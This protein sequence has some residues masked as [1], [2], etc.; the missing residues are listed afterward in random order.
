MAVMSQTFYNVV[1][2]HAQLLAGP[3]AFPTDDDTGRWF[4]SASTGSQINFH[5]EGGTA[6]S[7]Q[8]LQ[9]LSPGTCKCCLVEGKSLCRCDSNEDLDIGSL[10][11]IVRAGPERHRLITG[12]CRGHTHRRGDVKMGQRDWRM[13]PQANECRQPPTA[14]RARKDFSHEPL[15][16]A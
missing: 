8:R 10:L 15:R 9:A 7:L 12:G 5:D 1:Y 11:W 2:P 16:G 6:M 4:S 3:N 14:G 13:G